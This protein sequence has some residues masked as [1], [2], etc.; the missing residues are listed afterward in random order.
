MSSSPYSVGSP[1][2]ISTSILFCLSGLHDRIPGAGSDACVLTASMISS[3]VRFFPQMLRAALKHPVHLKLQPDVW[4]VQRES[5]TARWD[6]N[7]I[8]ERI[9]EQKR[10]SI[11]YVKNN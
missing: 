2:A 10:L 11:P 5:D 1:P 3:G 7:I 8:D 9:K 6:T 4:M